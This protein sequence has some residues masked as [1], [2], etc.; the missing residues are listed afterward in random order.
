M[1]IDRYLLKNLAVDVGIR[2]Q[3]LTDLSPSLSQAM[4]GVQ[5]NKIKSS[6]I[7]ATDLYH[8]STHF[9]LRAFSCGISSALGFVITP[10][11][12]KGGAALKLT[13]PPPPPLLPV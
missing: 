7:Y 4:H 6:H 12:L 1:L 8:H 5:R 10:L 11:V 13:P 3:R 2:T 9:I